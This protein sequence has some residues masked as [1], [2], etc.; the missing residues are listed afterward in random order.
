VVEETGKAFFAQ[1]LKIVD[2]KFISDE[3][4]AIIAPT[5]PSDP[6]KMD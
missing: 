5:M 6:L 2:M 3:K 4:S 1:H